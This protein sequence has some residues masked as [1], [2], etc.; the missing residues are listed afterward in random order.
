[1]IGRRAWGGPQVVRRTVGVSSWL[2]LFSV[3]TFRGL[4]RLAAVLGG[5]AAVTTA[6]CFVLLLALLLP[7]VPVLAAEQK[8]VP[9]VSVPMSER[10]CLAI[11]SFDDGSIQ[12]QEW[13][14]STWDVGSGLANILTTVLLERNQFRL[15][16]RSLLEKVVAEQDLGE[17]SRVNAKTAAQA[18]KITGADYLLMGKVTQFSAETKSAGGLAG[19]AGGIVGVGQSKTKARVAIDVRV[20]DAE[21]TEILASFSG[22]GEEGR[23]KWAIGASGIGAVAIGSSD[24]MESVL[25]IA[26]KKAITQW[27]D[28]FCRSLDQKKLVLPPKHRVPVRPEGVVLLVQGDALVANTGTLKGYAVWDRVEVH[29]VAKE[30]KDPATG[31][32]L[33]VMTE[34]VATG[35]ITKID[36]KTA[37]IALTVIDPSKVPTDGDIVRF[38]ANTVA[39][40]VSASPPAVPGPGTAPGQGPAAAGSG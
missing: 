20:V 24:F 14:G 32:V 2:S 37:D 36:E 22:N 17:S 15:L 4:G 6:G 23:G 31:E 25:G 9:V 39:P 34:L 5:S 19:L 35:T 7:A 1:M 10:P 12:R 40:A 13:W 8:V 16:E 38:T 28:N 18:G 11:V 27:A 3:G 21:T 26:T 29:H 33:R 30:L